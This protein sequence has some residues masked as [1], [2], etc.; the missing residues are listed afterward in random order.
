MYYVVDLYYLMPLCS[1]KD[2]YANIFQV[3]SHNEIKWIRMHE[4]T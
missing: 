4:N 1:L 2:I 3:I